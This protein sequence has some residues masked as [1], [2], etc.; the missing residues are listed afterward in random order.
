MCN[1]VEEFHKHNMSFTD[2]HTKLLRHRV[3][4]IHCIGNGEGTYDFIRGDFS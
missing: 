2:E 4:G 1:S 3:D